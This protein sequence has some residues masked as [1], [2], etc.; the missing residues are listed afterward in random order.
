MAQDLYLGK[1]IAF[2]IGNAANSLTALEG[3]AD[4]LVDVTYGDDVPTIV[5]EGGGNYTEVEDGEV[6]VYAAGFT[7]QLGA[8]TYPLVFGQAGVKKYFEYG[9]R[10]RTA[11]L[12]KFT[13]S[14]Y[15]RPAPLRAAV[16]ASDLRMAFTIDI[17]G[18]VTAGTFS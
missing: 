16:G 3:Q 13:Y 8:T 17:D 4:G 15:L 10:G 6:H 2:G 12:P 11:G 7:V 9:P 18:Q 5:K 14:G 1:N